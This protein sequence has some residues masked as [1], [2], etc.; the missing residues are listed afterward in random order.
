MLQDR[1]KR[2]AFTLIELLVVIAI[3]AILIALLVPAV[4]KVRESS[5]RTQCVNNQ[6][7]LGVA[8]HNFHATFNKLPPAWNWPGITAPTGSVAGGFAGT[9]TW[10]VFL[11][12]YLELDGLYKQV[13]AA[14]TNQKNPAYEMVVPVFLCPSDP[15]AGRYGFGPGKNRQNPN[16]GNPIKHPALGSANYAGNVWVFNPVAPGTIVKSIPDGTSNQIM[17][18]EI[19][20]YCNAGL[21]LSGTVAG[22]ITT[23]NQDGAAWGYLSQFFQGG[24]TA[25]AMYG[26]GTS[27]LGSCQDF[28]QGSTNFQLAP[29]PDG[30]LPPNG[31]G[32]VE[33][34]IQTGHLAGMVVTL[35]DASVR[36]V[37][38][39]VNPLTWRQ[40]NNPN[41]GVVLPPDWN[42]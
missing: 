30:V 39:T 6:K 24:T 2:T 42:Q 7:Q 35:A 20:Q 11:M 41:D 31:E 33:N 34:A 13:M 9:G 38:A 32:C 21:N 22:P 27:G 5:A 25:V 3:I 26:C 16:D 29:L 19:Y 36:I 10:H 17:I 12:P 37:S 15:S 4:Q 8:V 23:G 40:A 18:C 14:P 1:R 28:N